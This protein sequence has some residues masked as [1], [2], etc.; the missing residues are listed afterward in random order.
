MRASCLRKSM[1]VF[2]S[3]LLGPAVLLASNHQGSICGNSALDSENE[4]SS[5]TTSCLLNNV[6][7]DSSK[8]HDMAAQLQAYAGEQFLVSWHADA[9]LLERARTVVNQMDA[10]ERQLRLMAPDDNPAQ[11]AV[12]KE[13]APAIVLLSDETNSSI[14]FLNGHED[15]LW[16][17]EF[18][19]YANGMYTYSSRI[20]YYLK[21]PPNSAIALKQT[22]SAAKS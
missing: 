11:R 14:L 1:L 7:W 5:I 2:L 4:T 20:D 6:K 21:H 10:M 15:E 12:I 3:V 22:P 9:E 18:A 8:V 13:I 17:P 19:D 16:L